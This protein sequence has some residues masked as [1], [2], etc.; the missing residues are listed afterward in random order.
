VVTWVRA[1]M[2]LDTRRSRM[3]KA[4]ARGRRRLK[5]ARLLVQSGK[6]EDFYAELKAALMDGVES[7]IGLASHGV[8]M[9]ELQARMERAGMSADVSESVRMETENCDFGR[10]APSTS[11]GE[12]MQA[13]YERVR[14]LIRILER[15]RVR[16]LG[17]ER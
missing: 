13:S 9:D 12:Q 2:E 5:K 3:R 10:F 4:W 1:R 11:R 14:K 8:T 16:P 7:R 17:E 6:A 15:E